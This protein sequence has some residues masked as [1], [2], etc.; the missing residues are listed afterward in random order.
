M[1]I[2][3][4]V[5]PEHAAIF[6]TEELRD[7]F[8]IQ[9]LFIADQVKLVYSYFDRLIVGGVCPLNELTIDVD[10]K[11]IGAPYLLDR[12]EMGVI[13]VGG[14]GT[15]SVDGQAYEMRPKDGLFIG[16]G[17]RDIVFSSA[18]RD[19]PAKFYL[20]CAPAH[21]AYP[22]ARV[23]FDEAEPVELGE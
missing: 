16:M 12:R 14:Q 2:R 17:S 20:N 13:N 9:D 6:D 22:T 7:Q 1:E 19:A 4:A 15:V 23:T 8:L 21:Q 5:H 10:E 11:I 18:D 3:N